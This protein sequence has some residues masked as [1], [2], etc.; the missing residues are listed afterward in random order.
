MKKLV[1]LF[2][3]IAMALNMNAQFGRNYLKVDLSAIKAKVHESPAHVRDLVKKLTIDGI[4]LKPLTN[5]EMVE[6]LYGQSYITNDGEEYFVFQM[7]DSVRM[8]R[9][10]AALKLANEV[11]KVNPINL[12]ALITKADMLEAI[13]KEQDEEAAKA[14]AR[15]AEPDSVE[16]DSVTGQILTPAVEEKVE[17]IEINP[18]DI[19]RL[20]KLAGKIFDIIAKT[21]DGSESRPYV[22]TKVD[23]ESLFIKNYL[24]IK[25]FSAAQPFGNTDEIELHEKSSK[26]SR[27]KIYFGTERIVEIENEVY[28]QQEQ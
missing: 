26:Y 28:N 19:K 12:N 27:D 18:D 11:L 23:E 17:K 7:K 16:I 22:I 8:N 24:G 25:D 5:A 2:F 10:R 1:M 21:G 3:A 4:S 13:K 9:H 20:R 14:I 6:A 15:A